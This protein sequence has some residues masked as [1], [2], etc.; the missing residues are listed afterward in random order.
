MDTLSSN[1]MEVAS[2]GRSRRTIRNISME[3]RSRKRITQ[4]EC[5]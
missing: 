1:N 2:S 5:R 4:L 3:R